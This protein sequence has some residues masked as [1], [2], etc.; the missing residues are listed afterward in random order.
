MSTPIDRNAPSRRVT[1]LVRGQP[2]SDG[3]GVKLSRVIGTREFDMLDPLLVD[4]F[5][6]AMAARLNILV[7]G[8]P[9]A[10]KTTLV[11]ALASEIPANEWFVVMEESRELGLHTTGVHPWAVSLEAREGRA[12]LL[13]PPQV[14]DRVG[15]RVPVPQAQRRRELVRIELVERSA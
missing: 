12:H 1:R 3:A 5:I 11:R 7:A 14:R 8:W 6:A 9:G 10:G 2:A 15:D 13:G 4:F